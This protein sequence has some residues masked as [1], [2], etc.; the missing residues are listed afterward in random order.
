MKAIRSLSP[1]GRGKA[2]ARPTRLRSPAARLADC[3]LQFLLVNFRLLLT[4][5]VAAAAVLC[6]WLTPHTG[7]PGLDRP[8][9]LTLILVLAVYVPYSLWSNWKTSSRKPE[10][11]DRPSQP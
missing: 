3:R 10:N 6:L 11:K 1:F 9:Q 5:V 2:K 8:M 7:E 4:L